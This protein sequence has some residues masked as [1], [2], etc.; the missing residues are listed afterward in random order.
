MGFPET[1]DSFPCA[2][3]FR[4]RILGMLLR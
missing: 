1:P 3:R 4:H 2:M